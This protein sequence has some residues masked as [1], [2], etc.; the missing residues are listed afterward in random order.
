MCFSPFPH[1]L[2]S[3]SKYVRTERYLLKNRGV[4]QEVAKVFHVSN[5]WSFVWLN[6]Y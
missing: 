2:F 5:D 6:Y 1:V 4:S 3:P